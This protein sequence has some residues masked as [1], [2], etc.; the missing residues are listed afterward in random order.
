MKKIE[1]VRKREREKK[2]KNR[3]KQRKRANCTHLKYLT[4]TFIPCAQ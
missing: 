2:D 3:K 4:A 1:K